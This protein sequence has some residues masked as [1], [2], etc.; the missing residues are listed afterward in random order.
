MTMQD[1]NS[2][3]F[4]QNMPETIATKVGGKVFTFGSYRLGVHT[5]GTCEIMVMKYICTTFCPIPVFI[6]SLD[7]GRNFHC[8]SFR[9]RH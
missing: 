4:L 7:F 1:R 6:S 8:I 9:C 2:T 3:H 5:K